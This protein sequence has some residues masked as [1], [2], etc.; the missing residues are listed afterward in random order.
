MKS[1]IHPVE[2]GL[3]TLLSLGNYLPA[4]QTGPLDRGRLCQVAGSFVAA[5]GK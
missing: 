1:L 2:P 4:R 3:A 5:A